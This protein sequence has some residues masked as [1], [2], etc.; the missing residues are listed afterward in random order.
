MMGSPEELEDP[1]GFLKELLEGM[2]DG[3]VQS[4]NSLT[5]TGLR[6][7][8]GMQNSERKLVLDCWVELFQGILR[9][10]RPV[11]TASIEFREDELCWQ[12]ADDQTGDV[13]S[14]TGNR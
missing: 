10:Q 3:V 11:Y 9:A 13:I 7:V 12:L 8:R 14:Q 1:L 6:I 4:S 2:G 5:H